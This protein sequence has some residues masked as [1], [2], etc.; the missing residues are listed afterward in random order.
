MGIPTRHTVSGAIDKN[1]PEHY[2]THP[3]FGKYLEVV[4]EDA[5]PFVPELHKPT[6]VKND[7]PVEIPETVTVDT[8]PIKTVSPSKT[9]NGKD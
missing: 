2:L 8:E 4:A 3:V 6:T 7:A 9:K 1:T 5:K